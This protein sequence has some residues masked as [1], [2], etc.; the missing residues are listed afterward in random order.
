MQGKAETAG[1]VD[2][3]DRVAGAPQLRGPEEEGG[4]AQA[5]RRLGLAAFLLPDD[6]VL[7][8]VDIDSEFARAGTGIKL[9]AGFLE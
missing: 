5:L 1:F 8:L 3:V 6:D 2:G 4:F 7:V 9:P